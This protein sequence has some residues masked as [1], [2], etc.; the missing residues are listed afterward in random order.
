MRLRIVVALIGLAAAG[1]TDP[2]APLDEARGE[3][4]D[5]QTYQV[6]AERLRPLQADILRALSMDVRV[7]DPRVGLFFASKGGRPFGARL[8]VEYVML[9]R[10]D[11]RNLPSTQPAELHEYVQGLVR[12]A[13]AEC[14]WEVEEVDAY[15]YENQ[16]RIRG[17][18]RGQGKQPTAGAG[19]DVLP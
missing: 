4:N 8:V 3:I 19:L 1:C 17:R 15:T 16:W 18:I 12:S 9:I 7:R 5:I 13:L 11:E 14:G 6:Q 2:R 10:L